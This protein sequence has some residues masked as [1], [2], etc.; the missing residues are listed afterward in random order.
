MVRNYNWTNYSSNFSVVC[1]FTICVLFKGSCLRFRDRLAATSQ[2][3]LPTTNTHTNDNNINQNSP[4][5]IFFFH[6][7]VLFDAISMSRLLFWQPINTGA[8]WTHL[9]CYNCLAGHNWCRLQPFPLLW[10]TYEKI[11]WVK[12]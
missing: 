4:F 3:W 10:I 1:Y 11:K 6:S 7:S 9:K 8:A 12:Y 5:S 2:R